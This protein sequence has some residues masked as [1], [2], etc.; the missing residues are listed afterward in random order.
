[1]PEIGFVPEVR[2]SSGRPVEAILDSPEIGFDFCTPSANS[3][4]ARS[5]REAMA[6]LCSMDRRIE[7]KGEIGFVPRLK[8]A[9]AHGAG[10]CDS[11]ISLKLGS[12]RQS[13]LRRVQPEIGFVL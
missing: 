12:F 9:P 11:G 10:G 1:M 3:S 5:C 6:H 8:F 2:F 13:L 4:T 7:N